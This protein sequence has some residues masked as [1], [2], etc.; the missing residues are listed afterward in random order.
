MDYGLY[1]VVLLLILPPQVEA[2]LYTFEHDQPPANL[3][4]L[5][6]RMLVRARHRNW[7]AKT[8]KPAA[9]RKTVFRSFR[10]LNEAY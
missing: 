1:G 9:R 7:L 10:P 8:V 5:I 6:G 2:E 3:A 4:V